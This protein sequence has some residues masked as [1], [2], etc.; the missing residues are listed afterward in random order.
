[1]I[2]SPSGADNPE[3][4]AL[5]DLKSL[6]L[7]IADDFLQHLM[8]ISRDR[9]GAVPSWRSCPPD[10]GGANWG[11]SPGAPSVV[12]DPAPLVMPPRALSFLLIS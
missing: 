6:A 1:V 2:A 4:D 5:V 8:S 12:T 10:C 11:L 7:L 9:T 3:C